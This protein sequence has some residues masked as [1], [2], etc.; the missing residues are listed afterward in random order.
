MVSDLAF[1]PELDQ[2]R[3][4]PSSS[5]WSSHAGGLDVLSAFADSLVDRSEDPPAT[6]LKSVPSPWARPLLFGHALTNPNHP[7]HEEILR[8]WK[9]L[10]GCIALQDYLGMQISARPLTLGRSEVAENA[11]DISAALARLA[12]SRSWTRTGLLWVDEAVVG[13]LSPTSLVFTGMRSFPAPVPFLRRGRLVDPV[14]YYAETGDSTALGLMIAWLDKTTTDLREGVSELKAF[15]TQ[16]SELLTLFEEWTADARDRA[17]LLL[18]GRSSEPPESLVDSFHP[19]GLNVQG[20]DHPSVVLRMITKVNPREGVPG[21][22]L[23]LGNLTV[24]PG[25]TGMILRDGQPYSGNVRLPRGQSQAV[26][27]GK[28]TRPL[29]QDVLAPCINPE[30]HFQSRLLRL[31]GAREGGGA[32]R[33]ADRTDAFFFPYASDL[34]DTVG[35]DKLRASTTLGSRGGGQFDVSFELTLDSG[36]SVRFEKSYAGSAVADVVTP[37]LAVW[38]NFAVDDWQDYYFH[39]DRLRPDSPVTF[40]PLAHAVMDSSTDGRFVWG[41]SSEWVP[42]WQA[43]EGSDTGL[44]LPPRPENPPV[45]TSERWNLSIDFGSTHSRVFLSRGDMQAQPVVEP[46]DVRARGRVLLGE[47]GWEDQAT[48]SFFY[49]SSS[50]GSS[51]AELKSLIRLP[52]QSPLESGT[53]LPTQGVIYFGTLDPKRKAPDIRSNLKWHKTGSPDQDAFRSYLS[54]LLLLV[55]CEARARGA[56]VGSVAVAHPS[57][58]SQ[59]LFQMHRQAWRQV[60]GVGLLEDSMTESTA[61]ANFVASNDQA[62]PDVNLAAIDIGGSTSDLAIWHAGERVRGE[63]IRWAGQSVSRL[64]ASD[65]EIRQRLASAAESIGVPVSPG[66]V[67]GEPDAIQL[68]YNGMLREATSKHGSAK[69]LA[70]GLYESEDGPGGRFLF[71]LGYHFAAFAFLMGLL[72]RSNAL[73]GERHNMYY[74]HFGGRGSDYLGWLETLH[75]NFAEEIVHAFFLQGLGNSHGAEVKVSTSGDRA[76]HEVGRGLLLRQYSDS[77]T[78]PGQRETI[79]GEKGLRTRDGTPVDPFMYVTP[80]SLGSSVS[81]PTHPPE[82]SS[83]EFLCDFVAGFDANKSTQRLGRGLGLDASSL[84]N[85]ARDMIY[86]RVFGPGTCWQVGDDAEVFEPIIVT[87]MKVLLEYLSGY[88]QIFP[89]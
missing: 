47:P 23:A 80:T 17:G 44:L 3:P 88:S 42:A 73:A 59:N 85:E 82:L 46:L 8:E 9:G 75:A 31:V 6:R 81:R 77:G 66:W 18:D 15:T 7:A 56:T 16:A 53:W 76:K 29:P 32:L 33:G 61:L 5:D 79:V 70:H 45:Q 28:L 36:F 48:R 19:A 25:A 65:P 34:L 89:R 10:W 38:P 35:A 78:A 24:N 11:S 2:H 13:G 22:D 4:A 62:Q 64:V 52:T 72:T 86:S 50:E 14:Q 67:D 57:A 54:Q 55:K 12:P 58:F 1:L 30:P 40:L 68:V 83:L 37:G 20:T 71:H 84:S 27:N 87:E 39:I 69:E 41:H 74:L 21:N 60:V 51:T 43:K 49:T 63:S 26:E